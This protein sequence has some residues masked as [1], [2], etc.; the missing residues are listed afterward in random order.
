MQP[1]KAILLSA[2]SGSG[3]TTII[4]QLLQRFDCFEFSISATSR[5]PRAN[6]K[7]GED[8]YFL[9]HDEFMRRVAQGDFVEWEEVYEGTCYGTLKS[10][11]TRIWD[12]GHCILFD[13]DVKGGMNLAQ[14]FD[15][16]ALSLFIMPPSIEVLEQRLRGRGTDH[17]ES[18]RKR[19][20][21]A[22]EE[23]KMAVH[24]DHTIINNDLERAVGEVEIL[25]R[26][27]LNMPE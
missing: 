19:L 12:N 17:E 4:R 14:Y 20:Q 26:N 21:R 13:V 11:L 3:K 15:H 24:F 23:L 16:K 27:Y 5:A 22:D 9:S 6:E 7:D 2:P 8:Y 10:E 25:V 1:H 18:I